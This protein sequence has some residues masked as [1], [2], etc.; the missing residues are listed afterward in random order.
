MPQFIAT[1]MTALGFAWK[2]GIAAE[3]ICR[4]QTALGT[5]LD[6]NKSY[7]DIPAV[8]ALTFVVAILSIVLE[9]TL[10]RIVR[11]FTNAENK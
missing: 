7:L 8:F 6:Q 5:L 2:S 9:F 11:R 10:K 4:P 1:S 3:V